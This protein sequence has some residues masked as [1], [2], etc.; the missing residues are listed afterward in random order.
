MLLIDLDTELGAAAGAAQ[1]A[2][3]YLRRSG[4]WLPGESI[5]DDPRP[6]LYAA[7]VRGGL[8]TPEERDRVRV[9][10]RKLGNEQLQP[11]ERPLVWIQGY[12]ASARTREEAEAALAAR[13]DYAPIPSFVMG[14]QTAPAVA[15][16]D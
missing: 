15:S 10:W 9:E 4:T 7:A 8:R 16:V 6:P 12:A 2:D 1:V 13:P 5:D 14:R 3:A 11:L